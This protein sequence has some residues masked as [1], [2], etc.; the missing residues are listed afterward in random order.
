MN[1]DTEWSAV[2]AVTAVAALFLTVLLFFLGRDTKE[3]TIETVSRAVLVDLS[4]P[5]L[6][7][8]TLTYKDVAV[9]RLSV[10]TIE[11]RNDGT[12]SIERT[13]FE[14]PIIFRF[15]NPLD[16]LA[17]TIGEK[18]PND[19]RPLI[20]SDATGISV[21]P[22][23]L[24]PG[25]KFRITVQL[26]GDFTEPAIEGRISGVPSISRKVLP[27][28]DPNRRGVLLIAMGFVMGLLYVYFAL[29]S[30][31]TIRLRRTFTLIPLPENIAI[32]LA[33]GIGSASMV[34]LGAKV[35]DLSTT[36][37]ATWFAIVL[38]PS[39]ILGR[40]ARRRSSRLLTIMKA[41]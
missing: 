1:W 22:L 5:A 25:D 13:D 15:K 18:N 34:A 30:S 23:L 20:S 35:L 39:I 2:S 27:E 16:V 29:F 21:S 36:Q 12:R 24:N 4:D 8:L 37:V 32:I 3:L 9:S 6:S 19:L 7:S 26:R 38:L 11:V 17:V 28:S 10:A 31:P 40:F 41:P 14:Q 33:L